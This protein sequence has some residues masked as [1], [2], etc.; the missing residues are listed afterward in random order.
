MLVTLILIT[1]L[2]AGATAL[3][4]MQH[5]STHAAQLTRSKVSALAC[6]EAGLATARSAVASSY[7]QWN[8]ALATGLQPTWLASLARDL[9]G[10]NE[11]D[12]ELTLRDNED[13]LTGTDDPAHDNDL[14]VYVV[15]TCVKYSDAPVRVAELVRYRGGGSCYDAQLGGCGGNNN[16][17]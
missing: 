7:A 6:A 13:E 8:G 12:F 4:S 16:G 2:T 14:A 5:D 15:S 11:A 17:N 9:D 1:A 10:D 3:V